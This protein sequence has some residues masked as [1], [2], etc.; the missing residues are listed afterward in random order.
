MK[1][2]DEQIYFEN[3]GTYLAVRIPMFETMQQAMQVISQIFDMNRR[4][5]H[6]RILIDASSHSKTLPLM[7]YYDLAQELSGHAELFRVKI[8]CFLRP[9]STLS[10]RFF[11]TASVNRGLNY[12]WFYKEDE[13][14]K[15]LLD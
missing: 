2:L 15:W 7:L 10:D 8:A 14:I 3:R 6:S 11:E 9:E 5:K 12:R 13:A 4:S 1:Q